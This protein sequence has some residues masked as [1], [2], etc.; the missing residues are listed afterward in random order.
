MK[1]RLF[2]N[3]QGGLE[4]SPGEGGG[5]LQ[6]EGGVGQGRAEL[7]EEVTLSQPGRRPRWRLEDPQAV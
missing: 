7:W 6:A 5:G 3:V 4:P 1:Q 2:L